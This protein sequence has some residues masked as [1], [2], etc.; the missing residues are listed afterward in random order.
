[1]VERTDQQTAPAGVRC[2]G[3]LELR[4]PYLRLVRRLLPLPLPLPP[5]NAD[6]PVAPGPAAEPVPVPPPANGSQCA[7][8]P[9]PANVI[10]GG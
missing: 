1:M 8:V 6:T 5:H 3:R 7:A 2:E 9:A 10:G 4:V